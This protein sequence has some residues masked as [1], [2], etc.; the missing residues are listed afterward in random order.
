MRSYDEFIK[1]AALKPEVKLRPHQQRAVDNPHDSMV[2][3]HGVGSGKTLTSI[4]KFEK[5]KSQGKARKA[6]IITPSGLRD[7]YGEEGV[8]KFTDSSYNIVGNSAERA[9]KLRK[10][11]DPNADYNIVSYEMYRKNPKKYLAESGADTVITDEAQKGK[12]EDSMTAQ[13]MK[14]VRNQYKNH[15]ALTGSLVSNSVG[16][17]FPLIDVV[18]NGQHHL[19]KNKKDF[20]RRFV[21]TSNSKKHPV[22]FNDPKTLAKEMANVIDYADY[23]ELKDIADMPNKDI[24][25]HKVPLSKE[26]AK[27]YRNLLRKNKSVRK[28]VMKKRMEDFEDMTPEQAD[29]T[30]NAMIEQRKL[31]NSIGSVK[32]GM[33]LSESAR[34]TPKTK[35]L[36]DDMQKH[37]DTTVDG[38]AVLFSNLVRGGTDVLERGL[39]DRGYE[40]GMFIGKNPKTGI[41]EESRQQDVRDYKMGKKRVMIVSPAGAEGVSLGNTTWEGVLDPHYNPERMNQMEARGVRAGGLKG[42]DDRTVQINRYLATMPKRFGIFKSRY[43]TPDEK[44]YQIAQN[45][46]V[47][48]QAFY[49]FLRAHRAK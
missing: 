20:E 47:Q 44:I 3:A 11:I 16:D 10:G 6:L 40:P 27:I 34:V 49:D 12:N 29:K 5:L 23:D 38:Q 2:I 24:R 35:R 14:D 32:P 37:L 26:Q 22:K 42:R 4:A 25:V 1:T 15:I 9:K 8:G 36:L 31:M 18:S 19:G 30:F 28:M 41:T 17:A 48:N 45:K 13:S 43:Q 21:S 46:N 33:S 7:N 39:K